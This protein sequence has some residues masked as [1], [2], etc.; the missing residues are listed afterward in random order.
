MARPREFDLDEAADRARDAFW[1]GGYASTSVSDLC[2]ATGQSVGSLYKAFGSKEALHRTGLS[3]YLAQASERATEVLGRE[4]AVGAL[5]SW[6]ALA[7]EGA[8]AGGCRAGCYAV[9][10]AAELGASEPEVARL[11]REH[12]QRLILLVAGALRR[13]P[14]RAGVDPGEGAELLLTV[15]KGLQVSGRS[16]I[17]PG[18]ARAVLGLALRSLLRDDSTGW[19]IITS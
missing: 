18:T 19:G 12:D 16:G 11:V 9:L 5:R 4:D 10:T 3:R 6:L 8:S 7:A 2:A 14:L 13:A 17:T 1:A 15:S